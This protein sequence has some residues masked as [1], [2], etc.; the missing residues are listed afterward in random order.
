MS[1][2]FNQG[3]P[4]QYS[5]TRVVVA[6]FDLNAPLSED[7]SFKGEVKQFK[8]QECYDDLLAHLTAPAPWTTQRSQLRFVGI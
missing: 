4:I 3:L 1:D 5:D 6:D 7:G 8:I 2:T